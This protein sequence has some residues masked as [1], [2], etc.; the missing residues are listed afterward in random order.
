[1]RI[2][3]E[4]MKPLLRAVKRKQEVL[5]AKTKSGAPILDIQNLDASYGKLQILHGVHLKVYTG[6]IVSIIGPN[7]AGKSTLLKSVFG[8][9]RQRCGEIMF[10]GKNI[11]PLRPEQIVRKGITFVP[12][13]RSVFPSLTV[14]ENL[15]LGAY[16]RKDDLSADLKKVFEKFPRLRE[17]QHQKAG[18][19]SG[20]EQQMLAIGRALMVKPK[21]ILLDEPSLGL[22]PKTKQLIFEKIVEINKADGVSVLVVE[23]NARLSLKLSDRAYVLELGKNKLEG[24]GKDLLHDEKVGHLYLGGA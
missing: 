13:G 18:L 6:E 5:G 11:M 20:G 7:G 1:M 24:R 17:R 10:Q 21:L 12:Q 4:S 15:K 8:L 23:Q 16:I 14:L 3:E 22:S 2:L 19:L 9:I